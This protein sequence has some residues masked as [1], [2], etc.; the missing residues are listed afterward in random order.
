VILDFGESQGTA[1]L[2]SKKM[3]NHDAIQLQLGASRISEWS[4]PIA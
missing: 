1:H 4:E 3:L 2:R